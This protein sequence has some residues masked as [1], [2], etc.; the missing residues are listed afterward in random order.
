[1]LPKIIPP[2]TPSLTGQSQEQNEITHNAPLN[3]RISFLSL[4]ISVQLLHFIHSTQC[5]SSSITT[6][7]STEKI[8]KYGILTIHIHVYI[9]NILCY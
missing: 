7:S 9:F 8:T 1:M 5:S 3:D 6:A 2:S 4:D